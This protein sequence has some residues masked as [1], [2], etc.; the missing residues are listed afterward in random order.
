MDT[1]LGPAA[2]RDDALRA[3]DEAA[4]RFLAGKK[5][6]G[7]A[8]GVVLDGALIHD[9]GIGTLRVDEEAQPNADSVF[10]IASMTK[11][12]TAA[13]VLSLRDDGLLALDD[14]VARHVPDTAGMR[15]PTSDA[16]VVTIRHLLTMSAGLPTDDPWGDRQQ[17]LDLDRFGALLRAGPTFAWTPGLRFEYSNLGY[18]ILGRVISHVAGREY[19][20][21][22]QQRLLDPLG[23]TATTFELASVPPDRLAHGYLWRDDAYQPE[24]F[25]PYGALASMGGVYSSVRDLARWVGE[26]TD[27]FPPRDD[28]DTGHPL[29]RG[30]RREMQ[31]IQRAIPA[32]L[33]VAAPD[34]PAELETGGYGFG[35]FVM[36]DLR[37][38]R[39]VGHSGG[40][41]GFGSNMRWQPASGLGVI[42]LTNH[43]Y[44]P[45]TSLA[46]ELM[47]S[48]L[49]AGQAVSVPRGH[50]ASPA[51]VAARQAVEGLLTAW[52][53]AVAADLFAMNV[54]LDEPLV[55]RRAEIERLRAVHGALVVDPDEP[56]VLLSRLDMEWWMRGER[57]RVKVGI[58][59]S[60]EPEPRIQDLTLTSVPDP[61]SEL[62][63]HAE[64]LAA[65]LAGEPGSL[66]DALPD[67]PLAEAVDRSALERAFQSAAL[68]FGPMRLGPVIAGSDDAVTWRLLGDRGESTL[69][70]ERDPATGDLSAVELLTVARDAPPHAD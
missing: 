13:T 50:A 28:A 39:I 41:P 63:G 65:T 60:P 8:Y 37:S 6:P 29:S 19:K 14:P 54:D 35:L 45:A 55:R 64:R 49:E 4:D 43:R 67:L 16:P 53:D 25:D 10:R 42:V 5:V 62:M 17:G 70:L 22:V 2:A 20:D 44:G 38:G 3:A 57:G 7:V 47:R 26:F 46:R 34:A 59:L 48:L 33:A 36:D 68:R 12:F 51:L 1:T 15:A 69:R 24:P 23:M 18:G 52:D 30:S 9:R 66:A 27:A 56:V 58:L 21:A 11:S 31:Q 32:G 61:S 40:Y